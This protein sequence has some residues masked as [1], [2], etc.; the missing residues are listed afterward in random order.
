MIEIRYGDR[1]QHSM[2]VDYRKAEPRGLTGP[3]RPL[4]LDPDPGRWPHPSTLTFDQAAHLGRA[5]AWVREAL[6]AELG[7]WYGAESRR[8]SAEHERLARDAAEEGRG[9]I[10]ASSDAL[11]KRQ[12]ARY[13]ADAWANLLSVNVPGILEMREVGG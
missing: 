3:D 13:H 2:T 10:L 11:R 7:A 9:R 6:G 4:G 5:P 1:E 8:L 12:R